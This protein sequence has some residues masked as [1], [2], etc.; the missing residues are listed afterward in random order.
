MFALFKIPELCK[1]SQ[2]HQNSHIQREMAYYCHCSVTPELLGID[3]AGLSVSTGMGYL[4]LLAQVLPPPSFPH[5]SSH[6]QDNTS[7]WAM[8][9]ARKK[10]DSSRVVLSM[11][12]SIQTH[13]II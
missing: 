7:A 2:S 4:R 11:P 10:G 8:V 1:H 9:P 6:W 13:R 3:T 12:S 5:I